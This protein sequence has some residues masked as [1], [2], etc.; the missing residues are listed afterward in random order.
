MNFSKIRKRDLRIAELR[1]CRV[2]TDAEHDELQTL[3]HL[4]DCLWRRIPRA[5]AAKRADLARLSAY[6]DEIGL[7][8][9]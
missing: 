3:Q 2:L 5:L 7:G 1:A 8:P 4:A 9:C 6:A